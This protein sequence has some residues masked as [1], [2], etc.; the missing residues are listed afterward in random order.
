MRMIRKQRK[1]MGRGMLHEDHVK[2]AVLISKEGTESN[3]RPR[4]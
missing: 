3:N 2:C 1:V 4:K